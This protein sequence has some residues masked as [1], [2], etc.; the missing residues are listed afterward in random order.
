MTLDT[1]GLVLEPGGILAWIVVG[2]VA[3]A[4]ASRLVAGRGMGCLGDVVVG[5]AGA[6][7]GG[8]LLRYFVSGT[9]GFLGSIAVAFVGAVLLL[10]LLRLVSGS[11]L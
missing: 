10:A 3:G 6:F 7:I 5:V 11:R 2:L 4:L 1:H 8:L 9:L